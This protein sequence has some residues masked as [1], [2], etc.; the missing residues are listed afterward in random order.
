MIEGLWVRT[1]PEAG[2]IAAAVRGVGARFGGPAGERDW[3][4]AQ[5]ARR[6]LEARI[7]GWGERS[8]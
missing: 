4:K 7:C 5:V 6:I 1:G 2:V 3:S 8:P